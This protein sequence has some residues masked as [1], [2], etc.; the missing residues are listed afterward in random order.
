MNMKANWKRLILY[1]C[2]SPVLL[3]SLAASLLASQGVFGQTADAVIAKYIDAMGGKDK[4][5]SIHSVYQEG[6][7]VMANGNE[8]DSKSWKVQGQLYR[9]EINFGMGSVIV[10]VTPKQGWSSSP[11]SGGS[12]KELPPDMLQAAQMQMDPAG[13]LVDY[14]AKGSKAE[15]IGKDT[16]NGNECWLVDLTLSNGHEIKYSFDAKTGYIDRET[17]TGPGLMG[18]GR[19]GGGGGGGGNGSGGAAP[20]GPAGGSGMNNIDYSDYQKTA[21]G[22][23]FPMTIIAGGFGAKTSVEKLE[24]NKTVDVATLSKPTN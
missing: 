7:A 10:I 18:G 12:F 23:I 11:R 8:I 17:I 20:G 3:V 14:A 1:S 5:T 4:L 19:R 24:V 22:Y 9:Q 15:L 2:M 21:D 16:I 6:V 13:P